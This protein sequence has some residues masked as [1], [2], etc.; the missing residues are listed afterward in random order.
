[1]PFS[2]EKHIQQL[3]KAYRWGFEEILQII[4]KEKAKGRWAQYWAQ[5][6]QDLLLDVRE[7]LQQ[8]D[9]YAEQWIEQTIGQVYTLANVETQA[10]LRQIGIEKQVRPEFA[11]IHQRAVDVVAQNMADNLRD[12]TQF[13]GRRVNDIFRRVALEQAGRKLAAGATWQDIKKKVVQQLLDKGQTAFVDRIGR[14]WRLDTY[15]EMVA[16]TT[17]RETASVATLNTCREFRLNLV[18]ITTHYPTCEMCAAL[19]GKVFSI[20]GEDNRYPE[21]TDEYRPPIHPNCRHVL[22]PYVRELDDNV[23][24][25]ERFSNQSLHI[26]P[27]TEEEKDAY[28]KML[29]R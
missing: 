10:F 29:R 28:K 16:R 2:E 7:I 26:D 20:D 22:V 15:T 24:K 4:V 3:V 1:M 27:R 23:E 8:L 21:L 18:R 12:A 14:R 17:T 25:T 5:Y 9:Q 19:Q 6:W 13:V 11:Q